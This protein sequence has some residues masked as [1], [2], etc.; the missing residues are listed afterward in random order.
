MWVVLKC[1]YGPHAPESVIE[2]E[3]AKGAVLVKE[4]NATEIEVADEKPKE[5]KPNGGK[6]NTAR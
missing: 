4:G 1:K 2:I 5:E 6:R 3:D